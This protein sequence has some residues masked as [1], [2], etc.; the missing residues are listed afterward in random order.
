MF[1]KVINR[2]NF[3]NTN[4][5]LEFNPTRKHKSTFKTFINGRLF[6]RAMRDYKNTYLHNY[7]KTL[8][9]T[10]IVLN[11]Q[12]KF[13]Y[14]DF[15]VAVSRCQSRFW[16]MFVYSILLT[17]KKMRRDVLDQFYH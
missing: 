16:H 8:K 15:S 2:L 6:I 13:Y 11:L 1:A 9:Q 4:I 12:L 5:L 10:Y 17:V 7:I 14:I 3:T